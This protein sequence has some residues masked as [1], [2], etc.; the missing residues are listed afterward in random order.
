M[1]FEP[2]SLPSRFQD[3]ALHELVRLVGDHTI[4]L[5]PGHHENW[6][7]AV[8]ADGLRATGHAPYVEVATRIAQHAVAMQDHDGQLAGMLFVPGAPGNAVEVWSGV[9]TITGATHSATLGPGVL[10]LHRRT[11]EGRW[12]D[13]AK[14]QADYLRSL[15]RTSNGG[16]IHRL[17]RKELWCDSFWFVIPFLAE[18]GQVSGEQAAIGEAARQINAHIE[19]LRDSRTGLYRHIWAET[20]DSYPQSMFWSRGNGWIAAGLADAFS[21]FPERHP[22][23]T[24]IA[25]ALTSLI[26]ALLP[27]Q[28]ANGLW[29]NIIDD[30]RTPAESSGTLMFAYAIRKALNE[31]WLIGERY[32]SAAARAIRGVCECLHPNGAIGSVTLPP[33]GPGAR[34]GSAPYGQ[35]F[36][37]LAASRFV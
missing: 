2:K 28:E 6:E 24:I 14:R 10:D 12:L 4:T 30:S 17:E 27:A 31:G 26:D 23:R 37:L 11:G 32:A 29:H 20:P 9:R 21:F 15:Q 3:R 16:F 33:G 5:D 36:F 1:D 13:A 18:Y 19:R 7:N 34:L 35:G 22:S 8:M 25:E